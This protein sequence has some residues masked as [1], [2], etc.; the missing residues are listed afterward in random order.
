[1]ILVVDTNIIFSGLLKEG[2][3]REL[4]ITS[5]FDLIAPET[6]ISEIRKY[7]DLILKKSGLNKEDFE[8]LFGL[9]TENINLFEK[10]VYQNKLKEAEKLIGLD[11]KGDFPFLALALCMSTKGIWTEDKHFERQNKVQVWK[12]EELIKEFNKSSFN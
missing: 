1:M 3:T 2:K 7:E 12:T 8:V 11:E 4:L 10:E 5:P 6:I 9:L